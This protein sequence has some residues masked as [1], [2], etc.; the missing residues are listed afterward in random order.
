MTEVEENH[1][2]DLEG[3]MDHASGAAMKL[4]DKEK[5][6]MTCYLRNTLPIGTERTQDWLRFTCAAI[7]PFLVMSVR[8]Y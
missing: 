3:K 2:R 7:S 6:R 4:Q 5:M 1:Y 8:S